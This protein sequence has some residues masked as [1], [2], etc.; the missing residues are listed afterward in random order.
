MKIASA[1][2]AL[3]EGERYSEGGL[4]SWQVVDTT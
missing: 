1:V 2:L 4:V 3:V